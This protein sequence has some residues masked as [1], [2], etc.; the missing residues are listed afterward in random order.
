MKNVSRLLLLSF[1]LVSV[2]RA[3]VGSDIKEGWDEFAAEVK[4]G[5]VDK[6][7]EAQEAR[8]R[9]KEK[10]EK[11]LENFRISFLEAN[12]TLE[13]CAQSK[14]NYE[15]LHAPKVSDPDSRYTI[16]IYRAY[17]KCYK[18]ACPAEY[19][20]A[21]KYAAKF[22]AH[23]K[24]KAQRFGVGYREAFVGIGISERVGG[25]RWAGWKTVAK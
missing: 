2:L 18:Q 7:R 19:T 24:M 5:L 17:D 6:P 1:T 4:H 23:P 20:A 12:R 11:E 9:Q 3:D 25:K 13:A 22:N 8:E 14:C 21:V 15:T 10:E 16:Q